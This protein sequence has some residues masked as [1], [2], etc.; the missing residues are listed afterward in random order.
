MCLQPK[1]E[2][3]LSLAFNSKTSVLQGILLKLTNAV[4]TSDRA[5]HLGKWHRLRGIIIIQSILYR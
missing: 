2:L 5:G 3:L 1:G 4:I